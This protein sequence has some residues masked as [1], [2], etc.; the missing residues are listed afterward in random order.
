MLGR[1]KMLCEHCYLHCNW[2]FQKG[3]PPVQ[4]EARYKKGSGRYS[5]HFFKNKMDK[6]STYFYPQVMSLT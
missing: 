3:L 5:R 2:I 1:H 6:V 4:P